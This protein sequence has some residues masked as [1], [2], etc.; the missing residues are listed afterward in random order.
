MANSP[1]NSPPLP[2]WL[3]YADLVERWRVSERS[4]YREVAA[5]RLHPT[6][7]RGRTLF[8]ADEVRRYER[9]HLRPEPQGRQG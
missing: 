4:V 8:G 6:R 3:R 7:F 1:S 5:G 2:A 9:T